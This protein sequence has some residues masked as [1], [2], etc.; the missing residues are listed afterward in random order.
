MVKAKIILS[1]LTVLCL[2]SLSLSS[3][4]AGAS[5]DK[6]LMSQARQLY[7]NGKLD[8]AIEVYSKVKPDSD[9]W[10]ESI[11]ER[12]WAHTRKGDFEKALAD[13]HSITS[14]VLA[15]QV[16]PETYMLSSFVSLKICAYKDVTKKI[17]M[18]K[19]IML[20]RVSSMESIIESTDMAETYWDILKESKNKK[21][22]LIQLGKQADK[23]PRYFF[24]DK[25]LTSLIQ[26]NNKAKS[27][28]RL[29]ELAQMDLDEIEVNLKKMKIIDV[30][31]MQK[32]LTMEKELKKDPKGLKFASA[33]PNTTMTFPVTNDELWIDE[34]G[35][36]Q[37]K[38]NL[39]PK[40]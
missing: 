2:L 29:K 4:A 5:S 9:F 18:F 12:A 37:V 13:L 38:A 28:A 36:Y 22:G 7:Q 23:M 15:P 25:K 21:L 30:E 35:H 14:P 32:V 33:D 10:L 31:L 40:N 19:K 6:E 3:E 39:C 34:V 1:F 16:G 11:E 20:P 8:K 27:L 17:D 26:Q 24:R